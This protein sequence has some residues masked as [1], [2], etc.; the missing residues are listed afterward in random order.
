MSAN[1]QLLE[2]QTV[3]APLGLRFRDALTGAAVDEGLSVTVYPAAS[4]RQRTHAFAG[5]AGVYVVHRA[6]GL[7]EVTRG[8]GDDAF[9]EG[10]AARRRFT[11]EVF[12]VRR[13]YLPCT[14]GADLPVL[15]RQLR[16]AE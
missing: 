3:L 8:A 6:A 13:R 2:R 12:D 10:L 14:F 16:Q 7:Q 5:R 1:F 11:V 9:W 15:R 4:P